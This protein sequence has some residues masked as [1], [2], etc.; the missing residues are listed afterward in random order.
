MG[1]QASR[2]VKRPRKTPQG[3][4]YAY[5]WAYKA[6]D[7]DRYDEVDKTLERAKRTWEGHGPV[8]V[9]EDRDEGMPVFYQ[10]DPDP[11][12]YD[13]DDPS[14]VLVG[15][16]HKAKVDGRKRWTVVPRDVAVRDAW[17]GVAA[18]AGKHG[19]QAPEFTQE[20]PD[21]LFGYFCTSKGEAFPCTRRY[22]AA[23]K[24]IEEWATENLCDRWFEYGRWTYSVRG[25]HRE[26]YR[27]LHDII[28][29]PLWRERMHWEQCADNARRVSNSSSEWSERYPERARASVDSVYER[30]DRDRKHASALASVVL[31]QHGRVRGPHLD[32][33]EGCQ[34]EGKWA[35]R[36]LMHY[37]PNLKAT[38]GING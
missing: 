20:T 7:E 9:T 12:H 4:V 36:C 8:L 19:V 30:A 23:L 37:T 1:V 15:Y 11:M 17:K 6:C 38:I 35:V 10:V 5:E 31:A 14:G 33:I 34:V 25:E 27:V 21:E 13:T 22:W 26:D 28:E 18:W 32:A 2:L 16:M 29:G 3:N 24:R